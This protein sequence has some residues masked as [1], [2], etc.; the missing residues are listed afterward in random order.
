[1]TPPMIFFEE[2]DSPELPSSSPLPPFR[3][4]E[5]VAEAAATTVLD[6]TTLL[7][8]LVPLTEIMVVSTS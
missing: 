8:V 5:V 2:D 1:M 6:L 4:G 3:P 7:K